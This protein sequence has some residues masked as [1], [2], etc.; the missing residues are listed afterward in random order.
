MLAHT[1]ANQSK[2][3][4]ECTCTS[5]R[6]SK[7]RQTPPTEIPC[8]F[9]LCFFGGCT[10]SKS[11]FSAFFGRL[12]SA[13][14]LYEGSC[15][16]YLSVLRQASMRRWALAWESLLRCGSKVKAKN[17]DVCSR[18][19]HV[20]PDH[21][22]QDTGASVNHIFTGVSRFGKPFLTSTQ[23]RSF[24]RGLQIKFLNHII[25]NMHFCY[26]GFEKRIH[27]L[28]WKVILRPLN[29]FKNS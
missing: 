1:V 3:V 9:Y 2:N 13:A 19:L 18:G 24:S 26:F 27:I 14:R 10:F 11:S 16:A 28:Y 23:F 25:N 17:A 4:K 22:L 29:N 5:M 21:S 15:Q 20:Q 6:E 8:T 7:A 12:P